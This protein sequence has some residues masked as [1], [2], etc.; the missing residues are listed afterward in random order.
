MKILILGSKGNLGHQINKILQENYEVIAWD[1]EN[2][3][4]TDKDLITKKIDDLK[5]DI[6]INAV[7]YNAVDKC[8]KNN[9]EYELAK[10]LNGY[11][12]GYLADIAIKN[13][14]VLI[15][16]SSDYVFAGDKKDGYTE[17]DTPS[18]INKYAETKLFGEK[19]IIK[20]SGHGLKYYL[21]RTSKLFGPKGESELSKPSFFDI[22]LKLGKE[23]KSV[24]LVDDEMSCFTYT[25]DLAKETLELIE[26]K[27]GYG[28]YHIVNKNPCTWYEATIKLFKLAKINCKIIPVDSK[29][30][31]RPAKRPKYSILLNTKLKLLRSYKEALAEFIESND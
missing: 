12:V 21:I 30:F 15:H 16:Y 17:N 22:M 8:E 14:S 9:E 28:I 1:R 11:A 13:N 18:P 27:A 5:P 4:I 10:K 23:K 29:Y 3:D 19:E 31:P 24:N 2:I 6:I 20:R 7:A 26:T 25:P